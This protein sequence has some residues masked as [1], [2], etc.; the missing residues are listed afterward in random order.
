MNPKAGGPVE[1]IR[2]WS[3]L[4]EERGHHTEIATFDD[5]DHFGFESSEVKIYGLGPVKGFY[6]FTKNWVNWLALNCHRFD[7]V[8]IHGIWQYH[9]FGAWRVLK[10]NRVPYVVYT[11]GML[12]P[13]FKRTF[14]LKHLKK[15]LYWP[16][17]DYRVLRDASAVIFTTEQERRLARESF[18]FYQAKEKVL[19]YGIRDPKRKEF[20]VRENQNELKVDD[21]DVFQLLFLARLHP[22]KNIELL[23]EAFAKLIQE[24][25]FLKLT[26][27]GSEYKEGY[28]RELA[29]GAHTV[30]G[31]SADRIRWVGFAQGEEKA[32]LFQE[33]N[34]YVLPSHQENFG[35]SVVEALAYGRPVVISS[36]VNL[37]EEIEQEN[38]GGVFDGTLSSFVL[39]LKHWIAYEKKNRNA[40]R[41]RCRTVFLKRYE[42]SQGVEIWE[43]TMKSIIYEKK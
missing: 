9:S 28:Q 15:W 17:A 20:S 3:S 5:P 43:K 41:E 33:T 29:Q 38:V 32:Q 11:H 19:P 8:V 13:W 26:I 42:L 22:K 34:L 7:L 39:T 16:W 37:A 10:K 24:M 23:L 27:V 6:G 14:R 36:A 31:I 12:D 25:S 4:L 1:G 40:V 2:Q 21:E 35:I 18:W 30:L